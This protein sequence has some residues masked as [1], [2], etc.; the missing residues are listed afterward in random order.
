MKRRK[1][2]SIIV[3]LISAGCS[4]SPETPTNSKTNTPRSTDGPTVSSQTP[5]YSVPDLTLVNRRDGTT[6][7]KIAIDESGNS[8]LFSDELSL[9]QSEEY[10]YKEINAMDDSAVISISV[11]D[12]PA[13]DHDWP[14]DASDSHK[15]LEVQLLPDSIKFSRYLS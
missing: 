12:G 5:D 6:R 7:A 11:I 3:A 8:R 2:T 15:G 13:D 10:V 9:N 1:F 14:G 4:S